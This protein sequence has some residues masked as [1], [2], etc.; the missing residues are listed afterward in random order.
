MAVESIRTLGS[1]LSHVK[2]RLVVSRPAYRRDLG[3]PIG[4]YFAAT[5]VLD[6]QG[7]LAKAG[8]IEGVRQG[9]AIVADGING[10]AQELVALGQFVQIQG[11]LFLRL[12]VAGL[13]AVDRVLLALLGP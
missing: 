7:V 11:D 9:V 2:E 1:I 3:G 10:A 4:K 6:V 12:Q 5:Q 8:D 13:P